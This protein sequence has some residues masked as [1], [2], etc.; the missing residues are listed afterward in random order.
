M[1]RLAEFVGNAR[2]GKGVAGQFADVLKTVVHVVGDVINFF[3]KHDRA[4]KTLFQ[5]IVIL[6]AATKGY[7]AIMWLWGGGSALVRGVMMGIRFLR[8]EFALLGGAEALA[9]GGLTLIIPA[10]AAVGVAFGVLIQKTGGVKHAV[11]TVGDAF[12]W[13]GH[14]AMKFFDFVA[15]KWGDIP[16]PVRAALKYGNPI[17]GPLS[18]AVS[19]AGHLPHFATGGLSSGGW[20]LVG[21]NG[22]EI[23][24]L[25]RNTRVKPVADLRAGNVN[26]YDFGHLG[27]A[28]APGV[29]HTEVKID[30]KVVGEAWNT[31]VRDKRAR[32]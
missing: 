6:T 25:D 23:R 12:K 2:T 7:Q 15:K 17:S 28:M 32:R 8:W 27:E 11:R 9:T 20:S 10:A 14:E 26:G 29:V 4:T 3:D 30:R 13:V 24:Y 31:Y 21:E 19:L 22:P 5:S 1:G 16:G 18:G